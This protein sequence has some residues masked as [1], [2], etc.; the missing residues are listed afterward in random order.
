MFLVSA[1]LLGVDCKYN[2]K[3]NLNDMF[4][5]LINK[6]E[7]IPVCPEQLGGLSTPRPRAEIVCKNSIESTTR[8]VRENGEDVTEHF[9]NGA[10]QT[11]KIAKLLKIKKA[12]LKEKSP[13]CGVHKIYDGSFS[14]KLLNGSGVTTKFLKKNGISVFSESEF[15]KIL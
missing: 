13:S 12:V 9:I 2:G 3:N 11:L 1:C 8:V 5:K 7:F 10:E 14:G 4:V 15:K 6:Y